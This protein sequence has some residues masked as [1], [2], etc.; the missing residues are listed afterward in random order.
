MIQKHLQ[1]LRAGQRG[2][3][4]VIKVLAH[5]RLRS[6]Y[7]NNVRGILTAEYTLSGDYEPGMKHGDNIGHIV[8]FGHKTNA[9][10]KLLLLRIR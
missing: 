3:R 10:G 6:T 2:A 5:K 7:N 8:L 9:V 4:R 1:H